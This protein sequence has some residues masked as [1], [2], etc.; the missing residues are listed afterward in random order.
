MVTW[1]FILQSIQTVSLVRHTKIPVNSERQITLK[2]NTGQN[3][4][5]SFLKSLEI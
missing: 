4:Y 5:D 2:H 3:S 1:M